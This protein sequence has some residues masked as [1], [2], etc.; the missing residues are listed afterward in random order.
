VSRQGSGGF[1]THTRL[2]FV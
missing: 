2:N 1:T